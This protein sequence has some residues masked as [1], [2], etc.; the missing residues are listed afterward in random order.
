MLTDSQ[1]QL[2]LGWKAIVDAHRQMLTS[3]R[4]FS[5]NSRSTTCQ[6]ALQSAL[7][8]LMHTVSEYTVLLSRFKLMEMEWSP[9]QFRQLCVNMD[10]AINSLTQV[11]S[12]NNHRSVA[13]SVADMLATC[14]RIS[15]SLSKFETTTDML[16]PQLL[17]LTTKEISNLM[18]NFIASCQSIAFADEMLKNKIIAA[19]GNVIIAVL[20]MLC[21]VNSFITDGQQSASSQSF[22][23]SLQAMASEVSDS[24]A[25]LIETLKHAQT[26]HSLFSEVISQIDVIKL[27]LMSMSQQLQ[28]NGGRFLLQLDKFSSNKCYFQLSEDI[29]SLAT[30]LHNETSVNHGTSKHAYL[31]PRSN[32]YTTTPVQYREWPTQRHILLYG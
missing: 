12:N 22:G 18:P 19:A 4:H 24:K 16:R 8:T 30:A 25:E 28:S 27:D 13:T 5:R 26:Y 32:K 21:L 11:P 6:H 14:D 31:V 29:R 15:L 23:D 9:T 2:I 3:L 7:P 10:Q 1:K 20:N 17:M